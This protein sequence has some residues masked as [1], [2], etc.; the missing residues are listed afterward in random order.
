M[1]SPTWLARHVLRNFLPGAVLTAVLTTAL[2]SDEVAAVPARLELSN[3]EMGDQDDLCF[4]RDPLH[5]ELSRV[6]VSDKKAGRI[7]NYD[8]AGK[9]HQ[10]LAVPKP[11]NIDIRQNVTI[12]GR[13]HDVIA[14]NDR[15]SDWRIRVF[16]IDPKSRDLVA[17][18]RGIGIPSRP[19]YGGC[20]AYDARSSTLWFV[21]TS[22]RDGLTQ[23]ELSAGDAGVF[24]GREVRRVPLGKCEGAVADDEAGQLFVAVEDQGIW[25]FDVS[26]NS[27][28]PGEMIVPLGTESL[29]AD[30][31]GLT[32]AT[33]PEGVEALIVSS[34]GR[35]EFFVFERRPPWKCLGRF[36]VRGARDTDGIDLW[37]TDHLQ[38]DWAGGIFACHTGT[39]HH[40]VLL[41]PW[42]S[43]L[44]ALHSHAPSRPCDHNCRI[45]LQRGLRRPE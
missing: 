24:S 1:T 32:C 18:D 14:V 26:P 44:S 3:P 17:A 13:A 33:L 22:E 11:G 9:L 30:L 19:N 25:R 6:I 10:A 39:G 29:A 23:Y 37:Q 20:L 15:G 40:P 43:I 31:E 8:L 34:Q 4:L 45:Q 21:C 12:G 7:F 35:S 28:K 16:T 41:T 36:A 42:D 27:A 2:C 5:P 38:K